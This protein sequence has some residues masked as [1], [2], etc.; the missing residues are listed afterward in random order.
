MAY[1]HFVG[2]SRSMTFWSYWCQPRFVRNGY[3]ALDLNVAYLT[4]WLTSLHHHH[5]N[6]WNL[7]QTLAYSSKP[8]K[9]WEMEALNWFHCLTAADNSSH[10]KS[11]I[12]AIHRTANVNKVYEIYS[13][14]TKKTIRVYRINCQE[15][16]PYG[17]ETH[18]GSHTVLAISLHV[19]PRIYLLFLMVEKSLHLFVTRWMSEVAKNI[20]LEQMCK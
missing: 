9:W 18:K 17:I 8:Y 6:V 11:V 10:R 19:E 5:C 12:L 2:F 3:W 13:H 16:L 1:T 15:F 20:L 14:L 4:W 7:E